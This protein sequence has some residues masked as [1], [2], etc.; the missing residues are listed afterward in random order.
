VV[1][2]G[3]GVPAF[4]FGTTTGTLKRF[5]S[6]QD[7]VASID[8][9]L[10][11]TIAFVES[12][13]TTFLSPILGRLAGV[14]CRDGTLRSHLAIVSREFEVPCIVGAEM[15]EVPPDGTTVILQSRS[16][17]I[18][19]IHREERAGSGRRREEAP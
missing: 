14:I 11:N 7:V 4:D 9:D 19:L 12:G 6:P 16:D 18:G 10:G 3:R 5:S 17:G 13:G 2:I 1:E 8:M 15:A